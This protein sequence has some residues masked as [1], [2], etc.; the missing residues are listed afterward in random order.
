[1]NDESSKNPDTNK[2]NDVLETLRCVASEMA[3]LQAMLSA[4]PEPLRVL[5]LGQ[6]SLVCTQLIILTGHIQDTFRDVS[7]VLQD[8]NLLYVTTKFDRDM[9]IKERDNE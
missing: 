8:A 5:L 1:M 2:S 9:L 6:H 7:S 3:V 4:L